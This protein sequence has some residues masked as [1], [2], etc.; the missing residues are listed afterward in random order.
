MALP[1]IIIGAGPAGLMAATKLAV[2]GYTIHIYDHQQAPARKFLVAGHGG[3]NLTHQED[4][5]TFRFKYDNERM[6]PMLDYFS[7]ADTINFL[8]EIGIPTYIGSSGKIFPI[9]GIKPIQVLQA[10]LQY[11]SQFNVT[12]HYKHHFEDFNAQHVIC[13]YQDRL[14]QIPY[15]K[16]IFAMGGASWP[17]TGSTASWVPIF[18]NK[19]IPITPLQ[20]SNSGC[21]TATPFPMLAGQVLKNM[22]VHYN[23]IVK[24]GELTLT[25]YGIEGAPIY[26]INNQLRQAGFPTTVYLDLKPTFTAAQCT[27]G[28]LAGRNITHALKEQLRLSTTAISLLKHLPKSIY[29]DMPTLTSYIKQYS[30]EV[31]GLQAIDTVI[32]TAGGVSWEALQVDNAL[33]DFPDVYCIG[34]MVDW[35]AP[36]GGYLLQGC[37]SMGAYTAF[38]L[39]QS[40]IK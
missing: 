34:E 18:E 40:L 6:H 25:E 19:N 17:K 31:T 10:W 1:I 36:T 37:F 11:L 15:R 13:R 16:L 28:L 4:M 2:H 23:G 21:A 27:A 5:E 35:D 14:I 39:H 7:N 24:K 30:I 26:F 8:Q 38:H 22:A 12:F 3:F 20:P 9:K 32:S 29:T 33:K